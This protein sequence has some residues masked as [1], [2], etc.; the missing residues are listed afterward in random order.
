MKTQAIFTLLVLIGSYLFFTGFAIVNK[1]DAPLV[2]IITDYHKNLDSLATQID[3]LCEAV[4]AI[5]DSKLSFRQLQ[6]LHLKTRE[7]YKKVEFLLEYFDP[8]LVKNFINGAPLP[9]LE[10]KVNDV[11]VLEPQGLQVLDEII[12][13]DSTDFN[14]VELKA[15]VDMLASEFKKISTYQKNIKPTH[16]HVFEASRL[17]LIRIF[18]L[19][20]TGFDTPQSLHAIPEAI[21]ALQ[22]MHT[23]LLH[24]QPLISE[25]NDNDWH[26]TNRLFLESISFLKMNADFDTL[27]RAHFLKSFIDPLFSA[28]LALQNQLGIE[29]IYETTDAPQAINHFATS[30]FA[31]NLLNPSFYA[32]LHPSE[33]TAEKIALGKLL[34]FDPV[35]SENNKRSCASCHIPE[36]GF[37][38]GRQKSIAL[39]GNGTISRNTPT[40]LNSVFAEKYFLD[41]RI[42]MLEEQM[43]HVVLNPQEFNSTF[44]E[45]IEKI[46]KSDEYLHY[47]ED[48]YGNKGKYQISPWSISNAI[49]CYVATLASFNSPFDR[50]IRNEQ[51]TIQE[52]VIRGFNLFMGKAACGTCHF[53]PTFSGLVPPLFT[54]SESEVLGVPASGDTINP[55]I[56]KDPGRS[57]SGKISEQSYIYDRSFKTV[58]LRNIALTGPYMHN[59]VYESLDEVMDFYNKGGGVGL[60]LLLPNQT[61]ADSPL[62]LNEEEIKDIIAFMEALTDTTN[63]TAVPKQLPSFPNGS[64]LNDRKVGGEY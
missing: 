63:F 64:Y 17:E 4:Y 40:L 43:H 16:R 26:K 42:S 1:P 49:T 52:D 48:A 29:N 25:K 46:S 37:T 15:Q 53:A 39:N 58:T 3:N 41:L 36:K 22:S 55:M 12:F 6:S 33:L 47:F 56:D 44:Q 60:G 11:V 8:S 23:A 5:T 28:L 32:N 30:I 10:P 7:S 45:I 62:G 31:N 50:F 61:L 18:S 2:S 57:G 24:Y 20:L 21:A 59:G 54:E 34:F 19:G 14:P 13:G 38:D 51:D 35:L 9:R 27:D